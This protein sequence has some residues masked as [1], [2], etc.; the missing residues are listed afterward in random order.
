MDAP[1]SP[2]TSTAAL[3]S[4]TPSHSALSAT[5]S[6]PISPR[7][8]RPDLIERGRRKLEKYQRRSASSL[9]DHSPTPLAHRSAPRLPGSPPSGDTSAAALAAGNMVDGLDL[10]SPEGLSTFLDRIRGL[11]DACTAMAAERDQ[12]SAQLATMRTTVAHRESV[13]E[14]MRNE[15][16]DARS[17]V[18][19]TERDL[20][21]VQADAA[22]RDARDMRLEET[23]GDLKREL[24]EV[25]TARDA[26]ATEV[27]TLEARLGTALD[28]LAAAT[29]GAAV[30]ERER[31]PA[32]TAPS[33]TNWKSALHVA[34][35]EANG[36]AQDLAAVKSELGVTTAQVAAVEAERDQLQLALQTKD[37]MHYVALSDAEERVAANEH[38]ARV[39]EERAAAMEAAMAQVQTE[40]ETALA[41]VR[42]ELAAALE[43]LRD[44]HAATLAV[45]QEAAAAERAELQQQLAD[46][47]LAAETAAVSKSLEHEE[48]VADLQTNLDAARA[49]IDDLQH[50]IV[51]RDHQ[52]VELH[53]EKENAID[54]A[55]QIQ[56]AC[57]QQLAGQR[58]VLEELEAKANQLAVEVEAARDAAERGSDATSRSLPVEDPIPDLMAELES[59]R[60][61]IGD[62]L[63]LT[64]IGSR[65]TWARPWTMEL[66]QVKTDLAAVT[67][68]VSEQ[69][70]HV[71][72]AEARAAQATDLVEQMTQE[73]EQAK[74]NV[75]EHEHALN[76]ARAA[77]TDAQLDWQAQI[78]EAREQCATVAAQVEQLVAARDAAESDRDTL[79]E[80]CAQVEH[81]LEDARQERDATNEKLVHVEAALEDAK[82]SRDATQDKLA[83]VEEALLAAEHD[84]DAARDAI[85][86]AETKLNQTKQELAA[87]EADRSALRLDLQ[88]L[89]FAADTAR[90]DVHSHAVE[91]EHLQDDL[92][93]AQAA[94]AKAERTVHELEGELEGV[95]TRCAELEHLEK[96]LEHLHAELDR[97]QDRTATEHARLVALVDDQAAQIA[98]ATAERDQ[99]VVELAEVQRHR[100]EMD[101]ERVN[102]LEDL[103]EATRDR[104]DAQRALNEL[105]AAKQLAED[106]FQVLS[107]QSN[108]NLERLEALA[109]D[110]DEQART[111]AQLRD[112]AASVQD[113]LEDAL[114]K[115]M[116]AEADVAK[117]QEQV[118]HVEAQWDQEVVEMRDREEQLLDQIEVANQARDAI[119]A[120][121]VAAQKELESTRALL[122][123]AR[124]ELEA[125]AEDDEDGRSEA[126]DLR[127]ALHAQTEEVRLLNQELDQTAGQLAEWK[128]TAERAQA[129]GDRLEQE[130]LKLTNELINLQ[131][132]LQ[133]AAGDADVADLHKDLDVAREEA[134]RWKTAADTAAAERKRAEAEFVEAMGRVASLTAAHD[135]LTDQVEQLTHDRDTAAEKVTRLEDELSTVRAELARGEALREALT[136]EVEATAAEVTAKS[137]QLMRAQVDVDESTKALAVKDHDL[138]LAQSQLH[139]TRT[140][141]AGVQRQL[142]R[143]KALV[144]AQAASESTGPSKAKLQQDL[145][146]RDQQIA[147]LRAQYQA[148]VSQ[149]HT[150]TS[151]SA[152][153]KQAVTEKINELAHRE[154]AYDHEHAQFVQLER[155]YL[156][157]IEGLKQEVEEL[158]AA[159]THHEQ[160]IADQDRALAEMEDEVRA[161]RSAASAAAAASSPR[162]PPTDVTPTMP[163]GG[164]PRSSLPAPMVEDEY[165]DGRRTLGSPRILQRSHYSPRTP[166]QHARSPLAT[167]TRLALPGM[168]SDVSSRSLDVSALVAAAAAANTTR[169]G[170][171]PAST[172]HPADLVSLTDH[173]RAIEQLRDAVHDRDLLLMERDTAIEKLRTELLCQQFDHERARDSLDAV[174]AGVR[175]QLDAAQDRIT[176]LEAA[177]V[178][179]AAAAP[180]V[181]EDSRSLHHLAQA[182]LALK[183]QDARPWVFK[184]RRESDLEIE[185]ATIGRL[186]A[187]GQTV[188]DILVL[189]QDRFDDCAV[190]W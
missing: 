142:E 124:A 31:A 161:V 12:L 35:P 143:A 147:E 138:I 24:A 166:P 9:S 153:L 184:V 77:A 115:Q 182:M 37:D 49:Q 22:D 53:A 164:R 121:L 134:S 43:Q 96:D 127:E 64:A 125:R 84:R 46:A 80:Q 105:E 91:I 50:Q 72:E 169:D 173:Q 40:H 60:A 133:L 45:A 70:A 97:I 92:A 179:Q 100:D 162:G 175:R 5:G 32:R 144:A 16:N 38:R 189:V 57:D 42:D 79:R 180:N 172:G 163:R 137:E 18:A 183:E 149:F 29:A 54:L 65:R 126:S 19:A 156:H 82:Q 152:Q 30:K 61:Q 154:R 188:Q 118:K 3:G 108:A 107:G 51:S 1:P 148:L 190:G 7:A 119:R 157:Q 41:A 21:A 112:L 86:A 160:V 102:L 181:E 47:Q 71:A 145:A 113:Q 186:E 74:A 165:P 87:V 174:L 25:A 146:A 110:R 99:L 176:Q 101:G 93:T 15:V 20:A 128:R 66:N 75:V 170:D 158:V 36:L 187:F 85:V 151:K 168:D 10:A 58:S 2:S 132:Q 73:L 62:P 63:A 135:Q 27:Q 98:A 139:E 69:E 122:H 89:Q 116:A 178:T 130:K 28:E 114:T 150:I 4:P 48:A 44:V 11:R 14:A 136:R 120:D 26:M 90:Q 111:A 95:R 141:L 103:Q 123:Q 68:L 52:L 39:A 117:W 83:H 13:I 33:G 94:R 185:R 23:I 6:P 104:D 56:V 177:R 8:M 34:H 129:R 171:E 131:E 78:D 81:A 109:K 155:D 17:H 88:D 59:V 76:A 67:A 159:R 140:Q 55:N 167:T 106:R